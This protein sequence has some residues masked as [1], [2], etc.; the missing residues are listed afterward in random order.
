LELKRPCRNSLFLPRSEF[1]SFGADGYP[2]IGE[3]PEKTPTVSPAAK[4]VRPVIWST[5]Q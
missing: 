5:K 3:F 4:L 2:S 1:K